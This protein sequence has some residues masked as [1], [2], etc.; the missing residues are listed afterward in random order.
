MFATATSAAGSASSAATRRAVDL[1]AVRRAA[2]ARVASIDGAS[3]STPST[4]AKPSS[5]AA[6]ESTPEPQPT[7]SSEPRL[8]LLQ[9]LEAEPRRRVRAGAER[10]AGVDHDRE[11]VAGRRPPTA[12]R[13]RAADADRP[14][15]RAPPV[16]PARL[17]VGGARAA[18]ER[19]DA[20]LAGGVRVGGEL[21]AVRPVDLLEALGE[22]LEHASRAASSARSG[23]PRRRLGAAGSAERALQLLEEALVVAVGVLVARARR[24]PRAAAAARR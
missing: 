8:E 11:R 14:V 23:R 2:F 12:A 20:L 15:E 9:Q 3:T 22:E 1:D 24:T 10:A 21:D 7:S 4:G 16:L 19:P 5:A 18:E 17:D 13:P 6:I